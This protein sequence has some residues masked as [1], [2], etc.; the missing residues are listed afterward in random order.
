MARA[1]RIL[2][3]R[4]SYRNPD[5]RAIL[6]EARRLARQEVKRRWKEEGRKA[7]EHSW[8]ELVETAAE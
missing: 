7:Y 1:S 4:H 2:P 5:I 6:M 8:K 3:T